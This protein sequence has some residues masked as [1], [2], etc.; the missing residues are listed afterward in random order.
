MEKFKCPLLQEA[1]LEAIKD[2]F[3][4]IQYPGAGINVPDKLANHASLSGTLTGSGVCECGKTV[5]V[6]RKLKGGK[7][8]SRESGK[9]IM[10]YDTLL[11]DEHVK[12]SGGECI[13]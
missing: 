1:Y 12:T 8:T 2:A 9:P 11:Y 6:K 10:V 13:E 3:E 4:S 7:L 5:T